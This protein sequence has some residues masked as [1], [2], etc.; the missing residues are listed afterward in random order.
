MAR[1]KTSTRPVDLARRHGLSTQAV[2]NYEDAGLLPPAT[3]SDGGHRRYT[4]QHALA[5]DAFLAL[6]P[7]HGHATAR[8]IM[9]A[10]NTGR[11][12]DA[13][14]LID[15]SHAGLVA[16]RRIVDAVEDALRGITVREW[17][18]PPVSIGPV[19]HQLGIRAATLR[20]WEQQGLL[21]PDRDRQGYRV[22]RARDLRD[23]HIVGQLRRAGQPIPAI[24]LLLDDLRDTRDPTEATRALADRRAALRGRARAMLVGAAALDRYLG[25][26]P[27]RSPSHTGGPVPAAPG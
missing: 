15:R 18:G 21:R 17:N 26:T 2:R 23:A 5:L 12:D 11:L 24:R 8:T 4:E 14:D 7:G 1:A 16:E 20:R 9:V 13:L 22:Y 6:V 25:P 19:A 10:V 27:A 3:R